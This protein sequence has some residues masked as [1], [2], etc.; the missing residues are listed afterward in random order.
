MSKL[1]VTIDTLPRPHSY[2]RPKV[3]G[4][5]PLVRLG[6]E[7]VS[8]SKRNAWRMTIRV[9]KCPVYTSHHDTK[10]MAVSHGS[11]MLKTYAEIHYTQA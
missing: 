7:R 3:P 11:V 6:V 2:D 10:G 4:Y 1:P 5:E 9:D 8:R